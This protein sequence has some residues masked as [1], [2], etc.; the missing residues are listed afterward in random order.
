MLSTVHANA[1]PYVS[2]ND[3]IVFK[4]ISCG[5]RPLP[6]KTAQDARDAEALLE[7][8]AGNGSIQLSEAQKDLL[9]KE[10]L[11]D[12]IRNSD[13]NEEWWKHRLGL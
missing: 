10:V 5:L 7:T 6:A 3:L 13:H 2:K 12:V 8:A 4:I 1:L 11:E 9:T